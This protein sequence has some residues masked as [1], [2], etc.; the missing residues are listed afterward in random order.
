MTPPFWAAEMS[1]RCSLTLKMPQ[2]WTE[3]PST[4]WVSSAPL[5]N[6]APVSP[7]LSDLTLLSFVSR[8]HRARGADGNRTFLPGVPG[9]SF[10]SSV[11]DSGAQRPVQRGQPETGWRHFSFPVPSVSVLPAQTCS[12][13]PRVAAAPVRRKNKI[14]KNHSICT[15]CC[16]TKSNKEHTHSSYVV[17]L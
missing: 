9:L 11:S 16:S 8:L 2:L 7:H 5:Y 17:P 10:Q 1:P 14:K 6:T 13:V 15:R 4:P 3:A 12:Q